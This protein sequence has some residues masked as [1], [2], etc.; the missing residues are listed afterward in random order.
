MKWLRDLWASFLWVNPNP[1]F[2][3]EWLAQRGHHFTIQQLDEPEFYEYLDEYLAE[4]AG[5]ASRIGP[6]R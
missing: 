5:E 6:Y 2:N 1:G 3:D 4:Q